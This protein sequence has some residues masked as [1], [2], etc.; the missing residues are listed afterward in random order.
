MQRE[1]ARW[2]ILQGVEEE[3]LVEA[4]MIFAARPSNIQRIPKF[5]YL[6]GKMHL[7]VALPV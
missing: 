5:I 4:S 2:L 3:S 6:L 1:L 7:I